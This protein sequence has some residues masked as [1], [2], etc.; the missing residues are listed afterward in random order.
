MRRGGMVEAVSPDVKE[1]KAGDRVYVGDSLTGTCAEYALCLPAQVHPLPARITHSQGAA[2]NVPYAT[3]YRA[4]LLKAKTQPGEV[5]F[6]SWGHGR[7]W[8][9]GGPVGACGG[10]DR[11]RHG[12]D[13]RRPQAGGGTGRTPGA[14]PTTRRT[15]CG[16]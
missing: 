13:R 4:L 14:G 2:V 15:I 12:R 1:F 10:D 3:A 8:H 5:V 9:R 16:G 7:G 11:P 6:G